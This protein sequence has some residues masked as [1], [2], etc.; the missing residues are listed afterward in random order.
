MIFIEQPQ[1]GI[2]WT[3]NRTAP[4]D[5]RVIRC[6]NDCA[7]C[8]G[9]PVAKRI[10]LVL[11][12]PDEGSAEVMTDKKSACGG[13]HDTR[14]CKSCLSGGD[15]VVAVVQN[16]ARAAS[17]DMVEIQHS[18][19]A[20]MGSAGLFYIVPVLGLL[21]GAFIGGAAAAGWGMDESAGAI[22]AGM[23]G[24]AVSLL[25]VIGFTRTGFAR[26]HLVPRIVRIVENGQRGGTGGVERSGS[27][28][29]NRSCCG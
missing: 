21:A 23:A 2:N 9:G 28:A 15:K 11:S 8:G 10:G 4:K 20:L 13:C 1:S 12:L 25:G 18:T 17:G 16:D 22:L 27:P 19:H 14:S 7:M 29:P 6:R 24:L 5:A 3:E 26:H